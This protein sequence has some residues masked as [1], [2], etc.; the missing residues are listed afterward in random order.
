MNQFNRTIRKV[1][2]T[3]AILMIACFAV[4]V[5]FADKNEAKAE[6][7]PMLNFMGKV[8][9]SDYSV[10]ADNVYDFSFGLYTAD[11]GGTAV[12]S[13]DLT[14]ANL[15]AAYISGVSAGASS[16]TYTY[17]GG[18]N[19]SALKA[20]Q[21]L[22]NASSTEYELITSYDTTANTVTVAATAA[23]SVG[24][25][26]N[27]RPRV[28]GAIIDIDLGAVSDLS[29]VNFDQTLYLEIVF[30]SE[31][32]QPRK[33]I[34][35]AAQAF[36]ASKL[37]NVSSEEFAILSDDEAITG[38]WSFGNIVSIATSSTDAALTITQSGAGDIVNIFSGS[39]EVFTITN[40]GFVGI[41]TTT[42]ATELTAYGDLFLEGAGRYVY[43]GTSTS[44]TIYGF[45]DN[46][47]TMQYK[48]MDGSWSNFGSAGALDVI[49]DVTI[50]SADYG[51]LIMYD[52]AQS[53]WVDVATSSLGLLSN[54]AVSG[55]TANYLGRWDGSAFA[56]SL[57][58]DTGSYVGI[59]T[60][61][62]TEMLTIEGNILL[63]GNIIAY[64]SSSIGSA[65]NRIYKGYFDEIYANDFFIA[66]T[67]ISGTAGDTFVINSSNNTADT[68]D[69]HL[70]F[71]RGIEVPNALLTWNSTEDRFE[72]NFPLYAQSNNILTLGNIG[73]GTT[74]ASSMLTVGQTLG[75][76]FLVDSSGSVTGGSWQGDVINVAYGGTGTSTFQQYSLIYA[77]ADNSISEVLAG[78]E[79][80]VLIISGGKPT[81]VAS[82]TG[83]A[84]PMLSV[85]HTDT[86]PAAV[87]R[88]D[89]IIGQGASPTW[90]RLALGT[91]GYILYSD[92]TDAIWKDF[93]APFYT[94]F[95]ATTTDA[96]SEGLTNLYWSDTLWDSRFAATSTTGL[97]E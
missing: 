40:S 47:G 59:G 64:A 55:L 12:W 73:I 19:E 79:G 97:S 42:P 24:E 14:A 3:S 43:F 5:I 93:G 6:I 29:S 11:T 88:G 46:S 48:N 49:T 81:W 28:E 7:N 56:N 52:S 39:T 74:T 21:Y 78:S 68:E 72:I 34:T 60:T 87:V 54:S 32:M 31:T 38:E 23:W 36:N 8:V 89:L 26:I 1:L 25:E 13:E 84:H 82:S 16:T 22:T 50:T 94:Y 91:S 76:Q 69:S 92:G 85:S 18:S 96:L 4:F 27:N 67:S 65:A 37:D 66:S 86:A 33:L 58:Y 61:S 51:D 9:N 95:N 35:S 44:E 10:V 15:F 30:N 75:S 77:S 57:I 80:E 45:R 53:L 2:L 17:S 71:E 62:A 41:G 20:G 70:A 83:A 63:D 90:S